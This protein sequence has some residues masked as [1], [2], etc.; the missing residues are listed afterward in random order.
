MKLCNY[1]VYNPETDETEPCGNL[2]EGSTDMCASHNAFFRKLKKQN[3]KALSKR[4]ALMSKPKKVYA[5]P[6]K[7]SAKRKTEQEIYSERRDKFLLNKWC[8]YHG[9]PCIPTTVHHAK[10]RIGTLFLDERFW[11]PLC[12][13]AHE[14]VEKNPNEAKDKGLSMSRLSK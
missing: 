6:N 12:M 2:V 9:Q 1:G 10:G 3:E 13:Q 5:K 14:W 4:Q 8:A 11:V 7:I